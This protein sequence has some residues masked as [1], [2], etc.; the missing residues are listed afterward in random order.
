MAMRCDCCR[1]ITI[2]ATNGASFRAVPFM[3]EQPRPKVGFLHLPGFDAL[4]SSAQLGCDLCDV[5]EKAFLRSWNMSSILELERAGTPS[6]IFVRSDIYLPGLTSTNDFA[7]RATHL[8]VELVIDYGENSKDEDIIENPYITFQIFTEHQDAAA[9]DHRIVGRPLNPSADDA[10]L[11]MRASMLFCHKTHQRCT[12][13]VNQLPTRVIDVGDPEGNEEPKLLE[14]NNRSDLYVTLSHRWNSLNTLTTTTATLQTRLQAIPLTTMPQ[15][16]IDAVKVARYFHIQYL[17]IDSLC[18]LQDSESDWIS[19]SARMADIYSNSI[20]TISASTTADHRQGFLRPRNTEYIRPLAELSHKM[21]DSDLTGKVYIR[22]DFDSWSRSVSNSILGQRAWALQERLLAGRIAH[23]GDVQVFWECNQ[24]CSSEGSI[25]PLC[26]QSSGLDSIDPNTRER[27]RRGIRKNILDMCRYGKLPASQPILSRFNYGPDDFTLDGS[28]ILYWYV[29]LAEYTWRMLTKAQDKLPAISGLARVFSTKIERS[30]DYIAGLW[31]HDLLRGLLW[32]PLLNGKLKRPETYIAPSWSWASVSGPVLVDVQRLDR[33][34]GSNNATVVASEV[35]TQDGD[36]FGRIKSATLTLHTRVGVAMYMG[37]SRDTDEIP[38]EY[39]RTHVV[40]SSQEPED[41]IYALYRRS[42]HD[43]KL[44]TPVARC[45]FDEDP[46]KD[47]ELS[48]MVVGVVEIGSW[49]SLISVRETKR[50]DG[51][52]RDIF[53]KRD[54]TA[55]FYAWALM[56]KWCGDHD[57][58]EFD[59]DKLVRVGIAR[60]ESETAFDGLATKT[61]TLF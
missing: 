34:N 47:P 61:V 41:Y 18:I 52:R 32:R 26:T 13:E 21:P 53:V 20:F 17:W 35:E 15:T 36:P 57:S 39:N 30:D 44:F 45:W 43:D 1:G 31:K 29:C 38:V 54:P 50:D 10:L 56:V 37:D 28:P 25:Q 33:N 42:K 55:K 9:K 19:E 22:H 11:F 5:F 23:F 51:G 40:K 3:S 48:Q 27:Y 12:D 6:Q 24:M 46:G 58:E 60:M 4:R 7:D 59:A 2:D 14:T 16:F 8:T 49:A